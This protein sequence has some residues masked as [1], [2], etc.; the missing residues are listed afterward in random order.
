MRGEIDEAVNALQLPWLIRMTITALVAS[1][2]ALS[3]H[4]VSNIEKRVTDNSVLDAAQQQQVDQANR[5]VVEIIQGLERIEAKIDKI[6]EREIG[7][8]AK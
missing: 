3:G 6:N 2:L 8:G 7:R 1:L 4:W 5:R